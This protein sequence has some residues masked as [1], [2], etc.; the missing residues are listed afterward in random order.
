MFLKVEII[1]AIGGASSAPT[2]KSIKKLFLLTVTE[3]LITEVTAKAERF[4]ADDPSV[5]RQI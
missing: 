1:Y 5:L 2:N 3:G 4:G